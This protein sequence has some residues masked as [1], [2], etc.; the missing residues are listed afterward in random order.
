[1]LDFGP[2][3]AAVQGRT[4]SA[5][6][7]RS[8]QSPAS[9]SAPAGAPAAS[10]SF[11]DAMAAVAAAIEGRTGAHAQDADAA[12]SDATGSS[13]SPVPPNVPATSSL[14]DAVQPGFPSGWAVPSKSD[15][16]GAHATEGSQTAPADHAA[17]TKTDA[18][19]DAAAM[20]AAVAAVV[21]VVPPAP[22]AVPTAEAGQAPA[23]RAA[24]AN[25]D[26]P[27]ASSPADPIGAASKAG[28][29]AT[30]ATQNAAQ[31]AIE[32]DGASKGS[33]HH[34]PKG[35]TSQKEHP[36]APVSDAAPM[37]TFA[38]AFAPAST[39]TSTSAPDAVPARSQ[40][41]PKTPARFADFVARAIA[42]RPSATIADVIAAAA[43]GRADALPGGDETAADLGR[44]PGTDARTAPQ[45]AL[46]DEL[47][48]R[49]AT[50]LNL[51][52]ASGDRGS[53]AARAIAP[54]AGLEGASLQ[55]LAASDAGPKAAGDAARSTAA[56]FADVVQKVS[57][58]AHDAGVSFGFDSAFAG[59]QKGAPTIAP[60]A[61]T[62]FATSLASASESATLPG[63]T[64]NQIVQ[65]IR[66]QWASGGAGEARITLQPDQF[67]D[68]TVSVRVDRGQVVARV[69]ADAPVVREWLQSNQATLRHGLAEQN[70]ALDRLEVSEPREPRDAERRGQG[71]APDQQP[72]RRPRRAPLDDTF[73]V[74]A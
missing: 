6:A 51:A 31:R 34:T 65:A 12:S 44:A 59:G 42:S 11:A 62:G 37:A 2:S 4:S 72:Q 14:P 40:D 66:L 33:K 57:A 67:G 41:A 45:R 50:A 54:A 18:S 71:Q 20:A 63:E 60:S 39:S 1:M 74:V 16:S 36:E 15:A 69:E 61:A 17:D 52:A 46:A 48:A 9:T 43:A 53:A 32:D 58:P 21:P 56:A 7:G 27:A 70:L 23:G 38:R 68:V 5:P 22:V 30:A 28:L 24:D 47:R 49:A 64:V 10:S 13:P 29:A 55:A 19:A 3:P 25:G 35:R 8:A 26:T 73:E